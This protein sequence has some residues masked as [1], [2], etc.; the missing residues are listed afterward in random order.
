MTIVAHVIS[1]KRISVF[2]SVLLGH[3]IFH[4]EGIKERSIGAAIMIVGVVFITL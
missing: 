3:F 2:F 1:I 4:E